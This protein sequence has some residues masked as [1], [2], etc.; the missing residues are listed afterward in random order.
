VSTPDSVHQSVLLPVVPRLTVVPRP[1]PTSERVRAVVRDMPPAVVAAAGLMAIQTVAFLAGRLLAVNLTYDMFIDSTE[2][3][4]VLGALSFLSIIVIV[5][6]IAFGHRGLHAIPD[7]E[8][9]TR[10][11]TAIVLGVGYL[12]LILWITRVI[13][14]AIATASVQSSAM[15]MPNIFWWG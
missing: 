2:T 12:H 5:G 3:A 4:R 6:A 15:L 9:L 1:V 11:V 13:T 8:R 7:T 14:A 10:Q